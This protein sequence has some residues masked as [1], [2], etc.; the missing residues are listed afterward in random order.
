MALCPLIGSSQTAEWTL[1][2]D[3][4]TE[5]LMRDVEYLMAADNQESFA[6]VKTDN[7]LVE[8]VTRV[9]FSKMTGDVV[10]PVADRDFALFSNCVN[11]TIAIRCAADSRADIYDMAGALLVST[12]IASGTATIDVT[13]LPQGVYIL[14]VGGTSVKFI[15]K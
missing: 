9:T 6:V 13:A 10:D 4:G 15:K 14:C 7:T 3:N 1:V 5:I 11:N 2:T 8:G 12:W